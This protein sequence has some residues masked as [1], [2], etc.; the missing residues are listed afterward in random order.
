[1]HFLSVLLPV[2]VIGPILVSPGPAGTNGIIRAAVGVIGGSE[3]AA[4]EGE[5]GGEQSDGSRH[6]C[7]GLLRAH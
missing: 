3:V 6:P 7:S 1:M 2:V 4:S 5:E